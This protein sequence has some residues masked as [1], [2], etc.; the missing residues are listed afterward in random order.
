MTKPP[1]QKVT[2]L[3]PLGWG[4]GALAVVAVSVLAMRQ[5]ASHAVNQ[6]PDTP[7]A[8]SALGPKPR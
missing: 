2:W 1:R 8:A 5:G 6:M 7:M 3:A 4:L